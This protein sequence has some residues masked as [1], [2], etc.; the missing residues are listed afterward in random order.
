MNLEE[1]KNELKP[2]KF[3]KGR[4]GKERNLMGAEY[5]H[6]KLLYFFLQR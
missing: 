1:K 3:K 4:E 5:A 2:R 6:Q